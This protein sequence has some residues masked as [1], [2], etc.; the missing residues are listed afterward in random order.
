MAALK[1][2][3][4]DYRNLLRMSRRKHLLVEGVDDRRFFIFIIDELSTNG[5]VEMPKFDIDTAE[6]L[7]EFEEEGLG[8]REK[9]EN[10][11]RSIKG[12]SFEQNLVGFVDREFREF[13]LNPTL[14]DKIQYHKVEDQLIWSRGHSIENYL[15]DYLIL[16]TP[17]RDLGTTIQFENALEEFSKIFESVIRFACSVSLTGLE[18]EQLST[19]RG[20]INHNIFDLKQSEIGI[21]FNEWMRILIKMGQKQAFIEEAFKKFRFWESIVD[22]ADF[23]TVRWLCH[24][25][26]GF[27]SIWEVYNSCVVKQDNKSKSQERKALGAKEN[28]RFNACTSNLGRMIKDVDFPFE[29]LRLLDID[30]SSIECTH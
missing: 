5:F 1:Y 20:S 16:R 4:A 6:G 15:F 11:Y 12:K 30:L 22:N 9:V 24:G 3:P 13:E 25:H 2:T 26:I 21:N 23:D 14:I 18:L 10:I 7:I 28:L 29:V 27:R 17:L 8:N 19:L